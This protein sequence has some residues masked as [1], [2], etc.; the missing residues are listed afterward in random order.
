MII[1]DS[2]VISTLMHVNPDPAVLAWLDAQPTESIWTTSI[3]VFEV[4][5]GISTLPQGKKKRLLSQ[6]FTE[7]LEQDMSSRVLDFNAAAAEAA[8][9]IGAVLRAAGQTGDMRDIMI[10]GIVAA[11]RSTLA[12]RNVKHFKDTGIR[13]VNPWE[14]EP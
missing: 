8:S 4:R 13:I 2:N 7:V 11:C 6:A 12:T 5:Y 10:A 9:N 14:N 3:C 1:L